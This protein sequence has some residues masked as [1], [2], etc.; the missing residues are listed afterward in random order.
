M[1]FSHLREDTFFSLIATLD[2]GLLPRKVGPR[3]LDVEIL[4]CGSVEWMYWMKYV[5]IIGHPLTQTAFP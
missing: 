2:G 3:T 4:P 5:G 1:L